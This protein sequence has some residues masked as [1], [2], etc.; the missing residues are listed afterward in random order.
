LT[1]AT[2][3]SAFPVLPLVASTMVS[4]CLSSPS[5]SARSIMYF[6]IRAFTEPDGFRYSSLQ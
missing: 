1:A 3:E 2:I 6:A 5:S 4:P